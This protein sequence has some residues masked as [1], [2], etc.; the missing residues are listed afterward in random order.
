M[1]LRFQPCGFLHFSSACC[2][3]M[4]LI[5]RSRYH[6]HL[7]YCL[8]NTSGRSFCWKWSKG[9][10]EG[11]LQSGTRSEGGEPLKKRAKAQISWLSPRV[12]DG[13]TAEGKINCSLRFPSQIRNDAIRRWG[14]QSRDEKLGQKSSQNICG[15]TWNLALQPYNERYFRCLYSVNCMMAAVAF[16]QRIPW[17]QN[18]LQTWSTIWCF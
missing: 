9:C 14:A 3:V 10:S 17:Q 4:W 13:V 6:F 8:P 18:K 15:K 11:V 5:L 2:W 7:R 16:Y 1:F 12:W